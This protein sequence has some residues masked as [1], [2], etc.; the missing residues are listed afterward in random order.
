MS[1]TAS[2]PVTVVPDPAHSTEYVRAWRAQSR[3]HTHVHYFVTFDRLANE[4]ACMCPSYHYRGG[5][6]HIDAA[7]DAVVEEWMGARKVR[8]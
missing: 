1:K 6:G 7:I 8:R 4:W 2:P 3:T 5:C